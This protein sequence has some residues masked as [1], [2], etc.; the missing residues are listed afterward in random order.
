MSLSYN[1]VDGVDF[2]PI[3][4]SNDLSF[5]LFYFSERYLTRVFFGVSDGIAWGQK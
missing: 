1:L 5:I 3:L 4:F 2:I